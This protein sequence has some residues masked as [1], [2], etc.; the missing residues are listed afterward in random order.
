MIKYSKI[1]TLYTRDD[2]FKVTPVVREKEDTILALSKMTD[3]IVEEKIDGTNAQ[4][5]L[6][7]HEAIL[8][9]PAIGFYNRSNEIL[10]KDIMFIGE[11]LEKVIDLKKLRKWYYKEFCLDKDGKQKEMGADVRI[12]GEVFGDKIQKNIYTPKGVRDFRVFDIQVGSRWLSP[13]GRNEICNLLELKVVPKVVTLPKFPPFG[14]CWDMFFKTGY[15]KSLLAKKYGRDEL[16]EGYILRPKV[17]LYCNNG[18]RV[19]GKIKR[20]DFLIEKE[21]N[22]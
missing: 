1:Q 14:E 11:T 12:F 5:E 21:K 7:F 4:I 18:K 19:M 6:Y 16:L 9:A 15:N 20:K 8:T 3:I 2:K 17:S 13:K 10:D 22:R